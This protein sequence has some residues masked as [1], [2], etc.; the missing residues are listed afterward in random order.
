MIA[1]PTLFAGLAF[2]ALLTGSAASAEASGQL[3][4]VVDWGDTG[5]REQVYRLER[6]AGRVT[7][8]PATVYTAAGQTQADDRMISTFVIESWT[9]DQLVLRADHR[10]ADGQRTATI[11]AILDLKALSLRITSSQTSPTLSL[12]AS[13]YEGRCRRAQGALPRTGG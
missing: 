2:A 7:L 12:G 6:A 4:C 9:D 11:R 5:P 1:H 13:Q 8:E 10:A 3:R